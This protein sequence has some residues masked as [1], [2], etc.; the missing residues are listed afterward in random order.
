MLEYS[1]EQFV[2][3]FIEKLIKR[4]LP[5]ILQ[6]VQSTY[7]RSTRDRRFKIKTCSLVGKCGVI[8]T[9][10]I[11]DL[12][13]MDYTTEDVTAGELDYDNLIHSEAGTWKVAFSKTLT[14]TLVNSYSFQRESGN[15]MTAR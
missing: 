6:G 9:D 13:N 11:Y 2:K 5:F 14:D 3:H 12:D 1:F 4:A 7:S 15:E 8:G 10:P